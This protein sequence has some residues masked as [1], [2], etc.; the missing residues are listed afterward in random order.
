MET[1]SGKEEYLS[2]RAQK[3]F[4]GEDIRYGSDGNGV[5][6]AIRIN[7]TWGVYTMWAAVDTDTRNWLSQL[8]SKDVME[9]LNG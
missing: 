7:E 9:W 4:S 6:V 8:Q 5:F 2:Q 3:K 1:A